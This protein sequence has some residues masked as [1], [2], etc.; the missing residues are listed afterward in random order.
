ML[1]RSGSPFNQDKLIEKVAPKGAK[2]FLFKKFLSGGGTTK[3][4]SAVVATNLIQGQTSAKIEDAKLGT[5]ANKIGDV[6]VLAENSSHIVSENSTVATA[7]N[8]NKASAFQISNNTIGW[9][10]GNLLFNTVE[11]LLGDVVHNI[12]EPAG[13]SDIRLRTENPF[14]VEAS[15]SNTD[16]TS[17][18]DVSVEA[19]SE[20]VDRKSVV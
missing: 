12:A 5:D 7:A 1:F 14:N 20:A 9:E 16:I 3:A 17:N 15:I 18:G 2:G 6:T 10:R 19:V 4:Q 11:T 13:A 8:G